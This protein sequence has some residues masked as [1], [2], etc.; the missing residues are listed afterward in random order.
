MSRVWK[1][2][3]RCQDHPEAVAF[4]AMLV[5]GLTLMFL[6]PVWN[7]NDFFFHHSVVYS[8]SNRF[9]GVGSADEAMLTMRASDNAFL[10][11]EGIDDNYEYYSPTAQSIRA[12]TRG[13]FSRCED[14]TL[15]G[16]AFPSPR[17]LGMD[18]YSVWNYLPFIA[19]FTIGKGAGLSLTGIFFFSRI[20]ALL[21][22]TLLTCYAIKKMPLVRGK[23][24]IAALAMIPV[25][26]MNLT[27]LSYD[28]I[29]LAVVYNLFASV[30]R[31]R[32]EGHCDAK[33]AAELLVWCF[34]LGAV[35][36]GGNAFLIVAVCM[37]WERPL[38]Q[39]K[40]LL[41]VAAVLV[42][43]LS[44]LYFDIWSQSSESSYFQFAAQAENNWSVGYAMRHP[45][46]YLL[47]WCH[48][49]I[50][51]FTYLFHST[52]GGRLGWDEQVTSFLM[53]V[54]FF[55]MVLMIALPGGGGAGKHKAE[56]PD[57]VVRD[58]APAEAD[59]R[60]L[61]YRLW[62]RIWLFIPAQLLVLA[63]PMAVFSMVPLD[64]VS[65][66]GIQGRYYQPAL[67]PFLLMLFAGDAAVPQDSA[68]ERDAEEDTAGRPGEHIRI[69]NAA[70]RAAGWMYMILLYVILVRQMLGLYMSR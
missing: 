28:G 26:V 50:D 65:F 6:I 45:G 51:R 60:R 13:I 2:I 34:L 33:R 66:Y 3:V 39:T 35:K 30:L 22:H 56:M 4:F 53:T 5:A 8:V 36:G 57:A 48:T 7:I 54:L 19:V 20:C 55:I 14:T 38:K 18:F 11:E 15:I 37:L 42:C 61:R 10:L 41:P 40:N 24:L 1:L 12:A 43:V 68:P 47:V 70:Y 64:S 17:T 21:V 29:L 31:I 44:V 63:I 52:F 69:R 25:N 46:R 59:R 9:N 67:L 23:W 58:S 32:Y 27:A 49:M 62:E 16:S